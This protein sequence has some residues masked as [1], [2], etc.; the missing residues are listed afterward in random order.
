MRVALAIALTIYAIVSAGITFIAS[1]REASISAALQ[2][3][4]VVVGLRLDSTT[5]A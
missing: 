5:A 1:P 2:H 4:P 3:T